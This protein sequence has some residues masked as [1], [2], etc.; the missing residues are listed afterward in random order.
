MVE[1]QKGWKAGYDAALRDALDGLT[2]LG[3]TGTA[4]DVIREALEQEES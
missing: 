1:Y 2:G 3:V 4:L